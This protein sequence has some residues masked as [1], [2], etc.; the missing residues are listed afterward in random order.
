MPRLISPNSIM[1]PVL[2]V[3]IARNPS[4]EHLDFCDKI[5][6]KEMEEILGKTKHGTEKRIPENGFMTKS[7]Y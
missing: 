3:S 4:K 7:V 2:N 1:L 5:S 6:K